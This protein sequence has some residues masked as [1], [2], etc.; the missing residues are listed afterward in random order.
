MKG[1]KLAP[2]QPATTVNA[3][4]ILMHQYGI[5]IIIIIIIKIMF[6]SQE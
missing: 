3:S 1:L 2:P 4:S 6:W 5:I